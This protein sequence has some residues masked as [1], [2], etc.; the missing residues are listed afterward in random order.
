MKNTIRNYKNTVSIN[1][2]ESGD[3]FTLDVPH[4]PK[5]LAI[6]RFLKKRGFTVKENWL[7]KEQYKFLSQYHK[8][9][10]KNDVALLMEIKRNG[11]TVEFG[12][13]KNL[14]ERPQTIW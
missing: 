5:W 4:Y 12:N 3:N 8:I 14:W 2:A 11:I 7:Y 9:G 13:I 6:I 10:Y 1:F